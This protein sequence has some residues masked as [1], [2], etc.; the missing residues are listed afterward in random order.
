MSTI[1]SHEV[2]FINLIGLIPERERFYAEGKV[3]CIQGTSF[4]QSVR[5]NSYNT[6]EF[7][8][9]TLDWHAF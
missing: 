2:D 5:S 4:F 6:N 9:R 3:L 8:A 7:Y 1:T